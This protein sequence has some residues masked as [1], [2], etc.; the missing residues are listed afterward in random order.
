MKLRPLAACL[1]IAFAALPPLAV[2]AQDAAPGAIATQTH[3]ACDG[4]Q[5]GA[6]AGAAGLVDLGPMHRALRVVDRMHRVGGV[7]VGT[8]WGR[9]ETRFSDDEDPPLDPIDDDEDPS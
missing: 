1:S 5:A 9:D 8:G 7:A 3:R 6:V 4:V 2:S